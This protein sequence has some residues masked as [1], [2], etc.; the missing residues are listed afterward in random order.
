MMPFLFALAVGAALLSA[1]GQVFLKKY[2]LASKKKG[3]RRFIHKYFSA[4]VTCFLAAFGTAV[5]VMQTMEFTVYYA[6]TSL[7][8]VFVMLLSGRMLG[9]KLD[10]EKIGGILLIV[11]GLII[12]NQ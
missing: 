1:L 2:A 8:F 11:I 6:V 7:N 10:R 4:S 12:F 3:L 9:E 5:Y